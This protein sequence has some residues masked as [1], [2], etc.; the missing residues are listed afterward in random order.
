M[1]GHRDSAR[2]AGKAIVTRRKDRVKPSAAPFSGVVVTM[3]SIVAF[4]MWLGIVVVFTKVVM[5]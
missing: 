3:L 1:A 5:G 2:K 4:L